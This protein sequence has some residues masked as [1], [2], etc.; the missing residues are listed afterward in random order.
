MSP[1]SGFGLDPYK[2]CSKPRLHKKGRKNLP[3][4]TCWHSGQ[5]PR[6]S[7]VVQQREVGDVKACCA[8]RTQHVACSHPAYAARPPTLSTP[9]LGGATCDG[10][11]R[12]R[13]VPKQLLRQSVQVR[14]YSPFST[15]N[16]FLRTEK[17]QRPPQHLS[18]MACLI[19]VVS[20]EHRQGTPATILL[21]R[22]TN[23]LRRANGLP[24]AASIILKLPTRCCLLFRP[25]PLSPRLVIGDGSVCFT[26]LSCIGQLTFYDVDLSP[27]LTAAHQ[28]PNHRAIAS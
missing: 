21:I 19:L 16:M 17:L 11:Q 15:I 7:S 3:T 23:D 2:A 10:G 6:I 1:A 13:P 20:W 25:L 12:G 4:S 22:L 24:A 9:L 8:Q 5:S 26:F 18:L 28:R 14:L 27:S